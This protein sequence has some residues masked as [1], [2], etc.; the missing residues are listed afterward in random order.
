[1]DIGANHFNVRTNMLNM[2]IFIQYVQR[3]ERDVMQL[4]QTTVCME[5]TTLTEIT[6]VTHN[7]KFIPLE[8]KSYL[9][10]RWFTQLH[11]SNN[12]LVTQLVLLNN[13]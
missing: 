10:K 2:V 6:S 5:Q 11:S 13:S 4:P 7:Q 1:M 9:L 8:K 12:K 3:P